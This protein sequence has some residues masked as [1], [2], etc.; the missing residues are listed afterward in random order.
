MIGAR[1]KVVNETSIYFGLIGSIISVN[2][3]SIFPYLVEL[4]NH[5]QVL[6]AWHELRLARNQQPQLKSLP[7][8]QEQR[9]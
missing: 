3:Q 4:D 9:P 5:E 1:V 8:Q 6:F 2:D 7:R